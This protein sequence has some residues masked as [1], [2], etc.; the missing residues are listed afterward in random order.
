[1]RGVVDR[2]LSSPHYGERWGK[3][4]LDAA[5]YADSNGYFNADSDRPLAWRYRDW[6]VRA[7]NADQPF[8]RFVR[9]Q[10]AGDEIAGF[11]PGG[12]A[13]P[14][15][16][17]LLEATHYLRNSQDGTGESDGNADEVRVDRYTVI[18]GAIQ[19]V[20]N[21]LFG[22]DDPVPPNAN[23]HKFEP[24]VRSAITISFRP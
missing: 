24:T 3:Y 14:E 6:V 22:S 21:S 9:E 20:T 12:K 10:I 1:M 16:I 18:E 17:S 15:I 5:G 8:D 7:L 4:W 11:V 13:T 19:N 2:Y 23:D